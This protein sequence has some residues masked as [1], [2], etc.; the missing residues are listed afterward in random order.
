MIAGVVVLAG[1]YLFSS[2]NDRT[3]V[4]SVEDVP[5]QIQFA[6]EGNKSPRIAEW[7]ICLESSEPACYNLLYPR[8][9]LRSVV[10]GY[11]QSFELISGDE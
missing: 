2:S 1:L 6:V 3:V 10:E 8:D 4:P 7:D 5:V 11:R 9:L